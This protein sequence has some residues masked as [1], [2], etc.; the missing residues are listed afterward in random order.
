ML[1]LVTQV[2]RTGGMWRLLVHGGQETAMPV[3]RDCHVA[4]LQPVQE[5]IRVC[6]NKVCCCTVGQ[7]A[8]GTHVFSS[9]CMMVK[10]RN[11]QLLTSLIVACAKQVAW[12]ALCAVLSAAIPAKHT[13]MSALMLWLN[14]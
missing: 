13:G 12:L 7:P 6:G 8:A 2:V 1:A 3:L 14:G 10:S 5:S 4:A 9:G 11:R